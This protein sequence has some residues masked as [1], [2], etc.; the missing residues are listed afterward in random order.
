[1]VEVLGDVARA[2][3]TPFALAGE[4]GVAATGS[5]PC[6]SRPSNA[7]S[8]SG[9]PPATSRAGKPGP[10]CGEGGGQERAGQVQEPPLLEAGGA[11]PPVQAQLGRC[12][13][14]HH[15]PGRPDRC[16]RSGAA[17]P[18]SAVR[19]AARGTR[20]RTGDPPAWRRGGSRPARS[21][22]AARTPPSAADCATVE[23]GV[24]G[25]LELD[26]ATGLEPEVGGV[27]P[28][29]GGLPDPLDGATAPV[30]ISVTT[31]SCSMP[32]RVVRRPVRW[33]NRATC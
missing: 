7:P 9:R 26:L 29:R 2:R 32:T 8:G 33:N 22:P 25:R 24:Q 15:G 12:G 13:A 21:P 11:G 27:A 17:S 23:P 14:A 1:M 30:P 6:S 4:L 28:A 19:S 10:R 18:G 20:H 16:R 5:S 31:S 3:S